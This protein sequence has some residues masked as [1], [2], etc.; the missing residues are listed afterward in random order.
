VESGVKALLI[1]HLQEV[2]DLPFQP[3]LCPKFGQTGIDEMHSK[4]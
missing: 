2:A 1:V 4:K 3:P